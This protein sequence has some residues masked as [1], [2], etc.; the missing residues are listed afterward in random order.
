MLIL[1]KT[2]GTGATTAPGDLARTIANPTSHGDATGDYFGLAFSATDTDK[3]IAGAPYE[4]EDGYGYSGKAYIIN[5][6]TGSI[7]HT[8]DNPN[9]YGT[10]QN[11]YFGWACDI[12]GNYA[13]VG[14]YVEDESGA[15][16]SG[17][18]YIYNT[19]TGGLLHTLN[20]PGAGIGSP[21]HND[22]FGYAVAMSGL[23]IVVTARWEGADGIRSGRAYLFSASTGSLLDTLENPNAYGSADNDYFG[24]SADI[25]G[26]NIIIGAPGEDEA[27]ASSSGKAYI[28]DATT[29]LVT[30]TLSNPNAYN[31]AGGDYFGNAVAISGNYAIVAARN[32]DD[33]NGSQSGKAY[34]FNVTTGA[35][36]HTLDNPNTGT[37]TNDYFGYSVD[38]D[39]NNAIVGAYGQNSFEGKAYVFNV[40]TGA[41]AHTLDNPNDHGTAAGDNFGQVVSVSGS[42][43]Y[44]TAPSESD[45]SGANAGRVYVFAI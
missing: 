32:E 18:A 33:A 24:L 23:N 4:S 26:N 42:K 19:T 37:T 28:F 3:T 6:T 8:L 39:G 29:G 34:I 17:K 1:V 43:A 30:H 5:S 9:P 22:N 2:E 20:N 41:L 11:D 36:V 27:G 25:D 40:T 35:L 7:L 14:A 16:G 38:I 15:S 21:P 44:V 13:V 12:D 45:A 10:P 31:T